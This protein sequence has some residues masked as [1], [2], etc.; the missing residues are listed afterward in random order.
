MPSFTKS[1]HHRPYPAISPSRPEIAAAAAG[2]NVVVT[3]GGTG[4]GKAIAIAFAQ[5]GARSV[6][7]LGRRAERLQ[8]TAAEMKSE[9]AAYG[10]SPIIIT[11]VADLTQRDS[12]DAALQS[13][14]TKIT[15]EAGP[16]YLDVLVS[17]AGMAPKTG[18]VVGYDA[19]IMMNT[20]GLNV[21]SAF[22]A[23]NAWVPLAPPGDKA[24]L[25]NVS[26]M[27]AHGTPVATNFAYSISKAANLKM[28]DYFAIEN[29]TIHV[30]S[31]QPGIINTELGGEDRPVFVAPDTT[32]LPG[33]FCVWLLTDEARFLKNKFLWAN[34]DVEELV[35]RKNE[36]V[37]TRALI[38][39]VEGV[40]V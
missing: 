34:W 32:E 4:I 35:A 9:A 27:M 13:I 38:W 25:L 15:T 18:T 30:V 36:V 22:N 17:N 39:G 1:Y 33:Q 7:I 23:V 6:A 16:T 24:V 8:Q 2:K 28:I 29:P 5:A 37:G 12:V 21:L 20:L 19:D 10:N 26:T 31:F 11:E 40:L 14:Q 3:G